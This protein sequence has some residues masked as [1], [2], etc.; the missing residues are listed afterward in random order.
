MSS[1][2]ARVVVHLFTVYIGRVVVFDVGCSGST[3]VS[4]IDN[5]GRVVVVMVVHSYRRIVDEILKV[6]IE[7][8][9]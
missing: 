5:I 3:V 7:Q 1:H 4:I 2:S 6:L 9:L 8:I